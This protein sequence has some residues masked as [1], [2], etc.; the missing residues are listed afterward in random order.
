MKWHCSWGF[1]LYAGIWLV[2]VAWSVKMEK[3]SGKGDKFNISLEF[4]AQE[5]LFSCF[6]S[7]F[8]KK[9][10]FIYSIIITILDTF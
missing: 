10:I 1:E 8:L 5:C 6:K 7:I 2:A 9:N 3:A 4:G